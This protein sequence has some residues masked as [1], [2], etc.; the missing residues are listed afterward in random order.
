MISPPAD[1]RVAAWAAAALISRRFGLRLHVAAL[2]AR[3]AGF[4]GDA[5]G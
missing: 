2:V 1:H 5:D 4:V 3:E